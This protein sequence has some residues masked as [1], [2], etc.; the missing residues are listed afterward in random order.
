MAEKTLEA[1]VEG[2]AP[3]DA[4]GGGNVPIQGISNDSRRIRPG[5]LFVC[6]Q[7]FKDDGHR[8]V[9]E[10]LER[11]AAALVVESPLSRPVSVPVIRVPDAR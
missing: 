9:P 8:Y 3:L 11:G 4:P 7:G 1:L 2:L 6:I 10:A 5:F